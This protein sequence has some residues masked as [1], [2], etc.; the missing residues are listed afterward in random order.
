MNIDWKV[1]T[2]AIMMLGMAVGW[3]L[4]NWIFDLA[5]RRKGPPKS[6]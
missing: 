1:V 2:P 5:E 4:V 3:R 6:L